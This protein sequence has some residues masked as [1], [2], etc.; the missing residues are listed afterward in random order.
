[1]LKNKLRWK[2]LKINQIIN[3][4]GLI[5]RPTDEADWW[6][7]GEGCDDEEYFEIASL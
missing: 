7:L 4:F 5:I 2:Y 1:M 3:G 6:E